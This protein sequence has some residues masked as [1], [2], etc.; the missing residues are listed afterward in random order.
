MLR[1]LL[2]LPWLGLAGRMAAACPRAA[3]IYEPAC[4]PPAAS[5]PGPVAHWRVISG[6][7]LDRFGEF[8]EA[9]VLFSAGGGV[10]REG[11]FVSSAGRS[12]GRSP[13]LCVATSFARRFGCNGVLPRRRHRLIKMNGLRPRSYAVIELRFLSVGDSFWLRCADDVDGVGGRTDVGD[14]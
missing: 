4:L 8:R 12:R 6:T 9:I 3:V 7:Y 11:R 14:D 1:A 13:V 2:G 5:S 10:D